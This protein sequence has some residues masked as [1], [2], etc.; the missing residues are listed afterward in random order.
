MYLLSSKE[1]GEGEEPCR[2]LSAEG[3][4]VSIPNINVLT[5]STLQIKFVI[6]KRVHT[7]DVVLYH[8]LSNLHKVLK[9][10]LV[11]NIDMCIQ[12]YAVLSSLDYTTSRLGT[13]A[14]YIRSMSEI[15]TVCGQQ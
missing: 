15:A 8:N 11:D 12:F 13:S 6:F 10:I 5:K 2:V 1:R 7:H 3:N 9:I 4:Y 14:P